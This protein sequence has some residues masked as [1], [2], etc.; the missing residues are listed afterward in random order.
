[1]ARDELAMISEIE[2]VEYGSAAARENWQSAQ[3][4]NLLTHAA[5]NSAFWKRRIGTHLNKTDML[6]HLPP[7]TRS[8][9][10]LQYSNEPSLIKEGPNVRVMSGQT[11]GSTGVPTRFH[12]TSANVTFNRA[13]STAQYFYEGRPLH[14]NKTMQS[15][16]SLSEEKDVLVETF[17]SWLGPLESV[18]ES[19]TFR[20]VR[21]KITA[22]V[23]TVFQKCTGA[24]AGYWVSLPR[25]FDV[26][27]S[28]GFSKE[29]LNLGIE[30]FIPRGEAVTD[31]TREF[32][33]SANIPIRATYS[34]EELGMIG[35]ECPKFPGVYHVCTSNVIVEAVPLVPGSDFKQLLVT[36]LH[37]YATPLIRYEVGDVG[38]V[39]PGCPCGH[40]GPTI[41][42]LNGRKSA[43]LKLANG[44]VRPLSVRAG[45][46]ARVVTLDE[47]RIR[48]TGINL[49]VAEISR[50]TP[51]GDDEVAKFSAFLTEVAGPE[52]TI[53]IRCVPEIDWGASPKR[54]GFRCEI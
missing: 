21:S 37:S 14:R 50:A 3:L 44:T 1:M 10:S 41:T 19:G 12:Y 8:D 15:T 27:I 52:F 18:F 46:L 48:Q 23:E 2:L 20:T 49:L 43:L 28:Q 31:T 32:F 40:A 13:R 24:P 6:S 17:G 4:R 47:Y 54:L 16:L 36:H 9:L 11:S 38:D 26:A 25:L 45:H 51:F 5:G 53:E 34:S 30:M 35:S 29:V 33:A 7:L 22:G 42:Q 39:A